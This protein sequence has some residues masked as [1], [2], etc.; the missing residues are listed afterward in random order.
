MEERLLSEKDMIETLGLKKSD[1]ASM[2]QRGLK[3]VKVSKVQRLYFLSDVYEWCK[4][5]RREIKDSQDGD[6]DPISNDE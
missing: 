4:S 1:L 3:W 6:N 5:H 2:R